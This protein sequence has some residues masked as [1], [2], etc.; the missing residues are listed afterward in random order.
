MRNVLT[1]AVHRLG[2]MTGWSTRRA[3]AQ[4]DMRI[5]MIHGVGDDDLSAEAFDG[6]LRYLVRH[7]DV[8]SLEEV[9]HRA[10]ARRAITGREV[11]LTF[12]DGLRNNVTVAWPILREY[13][14]PSTYFVCPGLIQDRRWLWNHEI[15]TRLESLG[16]A[17]R[18]AVARELGL[19]GDVDVL[20]E[21]CK[22][23]TSAQR[24][25]AEAIVRRATPG[26]VPTP[27]Q[28]RH[29]DIARWDDLRLL[30][31]AL[32]T[33]GSHTANHPIL[34]TLEDDALVEEIEGSRRR[35]EAVLGRRVD[36][37]CYPNGAEDE[38]VRSYVMSAYRAAVTTESGT[39]RTGDDPFRLARISVSPNPATLA[40]RFH[41]P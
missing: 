19:A 5:L 4:G 37:F 16:D 3:M 6:L 17:R 36:F 9:V 30:D 1:R 35:L 10:G 33:I 39:V 7:F 24:R 20:V 40:W 28:R 31:P 26:W 41:R 2:Y 21:A 11:A 14:V 8:L 18:P 23:M 22:V 13:D 27:E 29:H 32:V 15:G 12:D 25:T 34:P 38:R